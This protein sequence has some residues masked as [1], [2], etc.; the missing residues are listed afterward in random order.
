MSLDLLPSQ[1]TDLVRQSA[2]NLLIKIGV[3]LHIFKQLS[4]AKE[5]VSLIQLAE[6]TKCDPALLGRIMKG[7][8]SFH[9][10]EQVDEDRYAASKISAAFASAKGDAGARLL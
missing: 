9:A 4:D 3:D 7:L 6:A 8:A 2:D 10:V 1:D 5:A